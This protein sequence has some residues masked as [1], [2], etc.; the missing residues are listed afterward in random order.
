MGVSPMCGLALQ[1]KDAAG[2]CYHSLVTAEHFTQSLNTLATRRPYR[3]FRVELHGGRRFEIDFPNAITYRD[4]VAVFIAAGG[5][6]ILFD[7]QSAIAI[8]GDIAES[9]A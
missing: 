4:G 6:P 5:V 9:A 7:H 2:T 3:P 8:I 1:L